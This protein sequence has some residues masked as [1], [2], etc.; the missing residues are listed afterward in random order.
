[1]A[2]EL[3]T[4]NSKN[5]PG[6]PIRFIKFY[7]VLCVVH[8]SFD[9]LI[10]VLYVSSIVLKLKWICEIQDQR[11]GNG[12]KQMTGFRKYID[13]LSGSLKFGEFIEQMRNY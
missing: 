10:F 4:K 7:I 11:A 12:E 13:E 2:D 3:C 8:Y 6:N 5:L 9:H 1:M